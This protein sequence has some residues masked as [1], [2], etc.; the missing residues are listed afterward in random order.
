MRR[1]LLVLT[2]MSFAAWSQ[3][4]QQQAQAPSAPQTPVSWIHLAELAVP[5]IVGIAGAL[6]GVLLTNRYNA[7]T[8]AANRKHELETLNRE[9]TFALKR[10]VLIRVTQLLVQTHAALED[11]ERWKDTAELAEHIGESDQLKHA[12]LEESRNRTEY[13][14]KQNELAEATAAACLAVSDELWKSAQAIAAS[15]WQ[16][17]QQLLVRQSQRTK[18][19]EQVHEEIMALNQS[20]PEGTRHRPH[21]RLAPATDWRYTFAHE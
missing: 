3:P 15:I 5:G 4:A 18:T 10:D 9:H 20:R 17:N 2:F 21:R 12:V 16:A 7:A 6:I 13:L 1:I 14:S 19:V 8:N 11:W